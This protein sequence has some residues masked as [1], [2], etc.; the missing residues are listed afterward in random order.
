MQ[1]GGGPEA[2]QMSLKNRKEA[3]QLEPRGLREA[4]GPEAPRTYNS[5]LAV[6]PMDLVVLGP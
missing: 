1:Q 5:A 6:C 3:M 2:D 4:R